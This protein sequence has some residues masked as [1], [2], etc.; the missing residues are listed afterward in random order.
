MR[1]AYLLLLCCAGAPAEVLTLAAG[2]RP[3]MTVV[4]PAKAAAP[5]VQAAEDLRHYVQKLCGV[6]LPLRTDGQAV[7]GPAVYLDRCA[8]TTTADLPGLEVNPESYAIGPRGGDLYLAGRYPTASAFAVY[9]FLE[10]ELGI[11]WF[12]PGELWEYVPA[13][14]PGELQVE[15]SGRV[16][17]PGTSPRVW[18]GHQWVDSWKRWQLRN[19]TVLSEVV[20]RRQF[21]NNVWR[22]FPPEKY[23]QTHPE[24]YPLIGGKRW[25]PP[26]G[27]NAW[28]PC[29]SNPEV[30]RLVA[31]FARTW[32]DQHPEI[33]SFSVGMDDINHLCGCP[34]CRA[35]DP[36]PDSYEKREFSDRHYKFVNAIAREVAK[37]HPDKY[38]GTLIYSIARNLPETVDTL[39]PNVFGFITETSA[40]WWDDARRQADHALSREW[41]K[42]CRH[43][44]RY[45]YYGFA[46][47]TPR[48]YP[49][50]VDEQMKFDKS[51]G[52]EG[53]YLEVYTFL[54]HT[55][56]MIWATA[57]LQQDAAQPIDGLLAEY[58]ARL[59][60]PA[61]KT[62]ARY[63][64]VLER[65]YATPRPGRPMWEHRNLV[66]QAMAVTPAA[67][68]QCFA[69]LDQA[70]REAGSEPVRQRLA[71]LR[72]ALKYSSFPIRS[73][74][75]SR[76][77]LAA[78]VTDAASAA[79]VSDKIA[80]MI[81]LSAARE[82]VWS[83]AAKRDDLLGETVRG[84]GGMGY[85]A[86]GQMSRLEAGAPAAA[87]ALMD[88]Y[89]AHAPD[90]LAAAAR[91]LTSAAAEGD[92]A[93]AARAWRWI[94]ETR[95]P[96]LVKND[97]FEE[98]TT[99]PGAA[100]K[101]WTAAAATHWSTWDRTR[102]SKLTIR[103]AGRT[104]NAASLAGAES[105][106]YIQ[107]VDV[108]PGERY[109]CVAWAKG[110]A[111]SGT[112]GN[113][114]VRHRTPDGAW[115]QR[116]DLEKSVD[117]VDCQE[118]WRPL[119]IFQTVPEGVGKLVIMLGAARQQAG[120]E[121]L[122]DDIAL[123]RLPDRWPD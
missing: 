72:A 106:V 54:P 103:P 52:F 63:Y 102:Q 48:Y 108:K 60:G 68:D 13:G 85:L 15:L 23:A 114:T 80:A 79:A 26:A 39:E 89:R 5:V 64:E 38:I 8:K 77:L 25:I 96:N 112:A 46:C 99:K 111:A 14:Q 58:F 24:Y 104:G 123:Y 4:I 44:S 98:Q 59:F 107:N 56:P 16:V 33:D 19:Q 47:L 12:A 61:A 18:S 51:L 93:N 86:T 29:E 84:L 9:G 55:A 34:N 100:E 82:P 90:Q 27:E 35:W 6:E 40:A 57:K 66:A 121:I 71:V 76:E 49:H 42:R 83:A 122:F 117:A 17:S 30:I 67:L 120:D 110:H 101:D 118:Q 78:K 95:P 74:A 92:V 31:E 10:Q 22:V 116:G 62:V 94:A 75:L 109:L 7:A 20:P 97:G 53:M 88:W 21:Q 73:Y 70:D 41:A 2:G 28:R 87:I 50:F 81:R 65:S 119:V 43:L 91:K 32:F 115:S 36:R 1:I 45:D 105:A 37:T 69:L 3:Q 11:R 113:L